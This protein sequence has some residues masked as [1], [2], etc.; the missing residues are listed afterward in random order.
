MQKE[1]STP[2]NT[3]A[4]G[5]SPEDITV[6]TG[7]PAAE[8][9][10]PSVDTVYEVLDA[11]DTSPLA[12]EETD[13]APEEF[14]TE[15]ADI[16][17]SE[18]TEEM[19]RGMEEDAPP[20]LSEPAAEV[21]EPRTRGIDNRFD[22]LEIFIFSLA[23]VLLLSAFVF[24]H[25]IVDGGSMENTLLDGEHLII[26][27]LFY[28]PKTGDIVVCEDYHTEYKKPL[29]KR[30]IATEG[31]TVRITATA[32]YVDGERLEEDYV[33]F[34][35][36]NYRYTPMEEITVPKGKLFLMGDHRDNS[37]D[38]RYFGCVSEDAVLGRVLFR[39]SPLSRFGA[40]N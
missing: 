10:P 7:V 12:E 16:P 22:F 5:F 11:E 25:A 4:D 36:K 6:T 26:S 1:E 33:H 30:V 17:R 24:R 32:V 28:T 37:S 14:G 3:A 29:I 8:E 13:A 20:P 38:S 21:S 2:L 40:V 19:Y 18:D 27:D 39:Y 35:D 23:V 31:Q 34:D 15:E 9:E